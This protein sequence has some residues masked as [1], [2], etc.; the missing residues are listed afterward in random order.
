MFFSDL[1]R[2][3]QSIAWVLFLGSVLIGANV[4]AATVTTNET[5]MDAVFSQ[6]SFLDANAPIDIRFDPVQTIVNPELLQINDSIGLVSLF[7]QAPAS[8]PAINMFFVDS[9]NW[10]GSTNSAIVGCAL[11]GGND[12]VVESG[13]AAGS[14]GT[15]IMAHELGHNLGL[16]HTSGSGL[17]GPTLNGQTTLSADEV[18][19]ILLSSFVQT[20][21]NGNRFIE[22]APIL[23]SAAIASNDVGS[24]SLPVAAVAAVPLPS[25]LV[26]FV[27]GVGLMIGRLRRR[28]VSADT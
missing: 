11:V 7:N 2:I 22:I 19:T 15:E 10:C 8:S 21:A 1:R 26:L 14:H 28:G 23:I 18:A 3:P 12:I 13:A 9:I 6:Q 16:D 24:P 4:N 27:S 17:M 5:G 25:G 20:D